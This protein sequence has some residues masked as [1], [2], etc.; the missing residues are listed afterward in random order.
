MI[1]PMK[2]VVVGITG[3]SGSIYGQR[4]LEVLRELDG[5]ET[6]L[7]VSDGARTTIEHELER[8]VESLFELAHHVHGDGELS[9]PVASGSFRVDGM[10]V[11]PCSIKVLSGVANSYDDSLIVRSADMRLKERQPL[12]LM[13][14]ETPLHVGHLRLMTLAA[15]AGAVIFPPVPAM[16]VRPA[17]IADLVDHSIMRA[18]DQLGLDLQLSPRWEGIEAARREHRDHTT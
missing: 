13:I 18:C 4:L 10:I 11:A 6:H 17:S 14:R 5:V 2:R 8:S 7:V 1:G 3:A 15:E 16:Y 12:V 9:A